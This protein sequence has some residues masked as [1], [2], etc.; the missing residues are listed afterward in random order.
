VS[1][2]GKSA[3]KNITAYRSKNGSFKNKS[4][5][6]QVSSL[7]EKTFTQCA[8]FLRI[9]GG[10]NPLDNSGVHPERYEVVKKMADDLGSKVSELIGN[11]SL[12]NKIKI[13]KY[14][15]GD[16]GLH[17]LSDIVAELKKP[18][19][20]PR[21]D[22]SSLEFSSEINEIEDLKEGM[23]LDGTVTNVVNFGAFVDV[24]VHQDGLIHISKLS[25]KFVKNPH[26]VISVG[27]IVKTRVVKI[28]AELKRIS[29]EIVK[30]GAA[31]NK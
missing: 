10:D 2:I 15:A 9:A 26:E 28:D 29:L 25:D 24:G 4:E 16:L 8:G 13:E 18:G 23:V 17:T 22:F 20:D 27:D 30:S 21:K 12:V 7:G 31:I 6:L 3:A 11:E 5:L 14:A 1:G 19:F